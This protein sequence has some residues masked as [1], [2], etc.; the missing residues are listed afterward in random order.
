MNEARQTRPA[1]GAAA[2]LAPPARAGVGAKSHMPETLFYEKIVPALLIFLGL[3][4]L[5]LVVLGFAV[6][7][8]YVR[9]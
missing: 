1:A 9:F 8:G 2:P 3:L 5:G 7:F 4:M 6:I